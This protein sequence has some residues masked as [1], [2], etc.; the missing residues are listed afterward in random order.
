MRRTSSA[1]QEIAHSLIDGTGRPPARMHDL[2]DLF[3][4][5][6]RAQGL[7]SSRSKAHSLLSKVQRRP[8]E[9]RRAPPMRDPAR[10]RSLVIG[11][12]STERSLCDLHRKLVHLATCRDIST[13]DQKWA[14]NGQGKRLN[15]STRTYLIVFG[16]AIFP[17]AFSTCVVQ[18][19]SPSSLKLYRVT[20]FPWFAGFLATIPFVVSVLPVTS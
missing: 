8:H 12:Q 14:V 4:S 5:A 1:G 3:R 7:K 2:V 16:Y 9:I 17:A 10:L 19:L 6:C 13:R 20:S 18:R 11:R 15:Y